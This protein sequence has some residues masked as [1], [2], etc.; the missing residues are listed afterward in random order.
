MPRFPLTANP[1]PPPLRLGRPALGMWLAAV[2]A[3]GSAFGHGAFHDRLREL[4]AAL[5]A[6]PRDARLHF[7]LAQIF[8]QHGD[9]LM[10]LAAADSADEL[11]PGAFPTD[12][13]RG[14]V[15]LAREDP[16]KA[17]AALDRL[18]ATRGPTPQAL[19]LRART[20][21]LLE[22]AESALPD[23]RA[24]VRQADRPGVDQV[25][26]VAAA[27][28]RLGHRAEAADLLDRA[29]VEAGPDP[30]LLL[31]ALDLEIATGRF[32]AALR[33]VD[34]LQ[35]AAPR[36]EPWM[37]RRAEV[38][39]QTGDPAAARAAWLVLQRHLES[40]PNLER[41]SPALRAVAAQAQA[42]LALP[43]P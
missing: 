27:F 12:L 3:A 10:A 8:C 6:K 29:I 14:E 28:V 42:A 1:R 41:G 2:L 20:K 22:G 17:R 7:E 30:A 43:S 38:L 21:A 16:A 18:I 35:A 36:P 34:A 9:W 13:L 32:A 33:R 11:Q 25:R 15:L 23:Y 37:A 19:I 39:A 31:E 5:E 24:A 40:L 4:T 26:E